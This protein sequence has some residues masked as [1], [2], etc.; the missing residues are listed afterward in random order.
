MTVVGVDGWRSSWL[1][2]ALDRSHLALH[3]EDTL[4]AL[5]VQFLHADAVVVDV[6]IGLPLSGRRC[7]DQ[8]ARRMVGPR[9]SSVFSAPPALPLEEPT[10][11]DALR[12]CRERFGFGLSSQSYALRDK[13]A[14]AAA[15]VAS[16]IPI[17]E[18]HP[19]V[20]FVALKGSTLDY[21][22]RTWNGQIERRALLAADGIT[23]PDR[24]PGRIGQA[25]PD[26][27]LDAAVMAWTA[28]RLARGEARSLPDPPEQIE[29]R[30]VAIWY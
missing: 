25:P 1:G 15:L 11:Q 6:P 24:L 27:V 23:L 5:T 2:V 7:A 17:T 16:G 12:V 26:D 3:V 4:E 30:P 18:G 10:Y 9:A 14:E 28:R 22:K 29:G 21:P 8:E 19:E 13:I 20:S